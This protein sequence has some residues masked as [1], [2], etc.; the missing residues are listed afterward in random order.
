[1]LVSMRLLW[2]LLLAGVL[3][4]SE[5]NSPA[6]R[7]PASTNPK[8]AVLPGGRLLTPI[9][10]HYFTGPGTFGLAVS[11]DGKTVV[12]ADGGPNRY[13]LTILQD[14]KTRQL[15]APRKGDPDDDEDE[16]RSVFM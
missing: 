9:G 11:P 14:G 16:W 8:S 6:G 7:R 1:M 4:A 2:T 5:Y 15:V 13:S 12:S 3:F 10:E